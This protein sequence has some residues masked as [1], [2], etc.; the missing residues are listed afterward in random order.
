MLDKRV[1]FISLMLSVILRSALN[2]LKCLALSVQY[3][4]LDSCQGL[5]L[6]KD[7]GEEKK[8]LQKI[9]WENQSNQVKIK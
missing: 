6:W 5:I 3:T 9:R 7:V 8:Q 2:T 1:S 4:F